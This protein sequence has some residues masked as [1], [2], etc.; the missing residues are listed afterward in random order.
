MAA[1]LCTIIVGVAASRIAQTYYG[2]QPIWVEEANYLQ[3]PSLQFLSQVEHD[4]RFATA[5]EVLRS[6]HILQPLVLTLAA[7]SLLGW[8]YA[9]FLF[10][11][12]AFAIFL[13]LFGWTVYRRAGSLAY[14]VGAMILYLSL[15][16][17]PNERTGIGTAFADIQASLFIAAAALC[18]VN[19]LMEPDRRW[20][21]RFAILV[22]LGA[23]ARTTAASVGVIVC[24][25]M[26]LLY[27]WNEYRA[28]R[29]ARAALGTLATVLV[30][31]A[32]AALLVLWQLGDL[33][34]YY[35]FNWVLGH[36]IAVSATNMRNIV[37]G[38]VGRPAILVCLLLFGLG[39]IWAVRGGAGGR[40]AEAGQGRRPGQGLRI[41]SP[42]LGALWWAV[43]FL[44]FLLVRG[45]TSDVPKEMMYAVPAF[46]LVAVSPVA[47]SHGRN[48]RGWRAVGVAMMVFGLASFGRNVT[49]SMQS[50]AH[51]ERRGAAMRQAQL[52]MAA[53]LAGLPAGI[54][55]QSYAAADW[56]IPVSL[57]TH[58]RFG[59]FREAKNTLFHNT[60]SYW[61]GYYPGA[62]AAE[63]QRQLYAKTVDSV[64]VAIVLKDAAQKP[65]RMEDYSYGMAAYIAE[66][67]QSDGRWRYVGELSGEPYGSKLAIYARAPR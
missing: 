13:G 27:L 50:A 31:V 4:G 29:Q 7:P 48:G 65:D 24:G 43:G 64:D 49:M 33:L 15:R 9:H 46:V 38:F 20:I 67:V 44:G 52:E 54:T 62:S 18:L 2:H 34:W 25:P 42:E 11:L 59:K 41:G 51:V 36:T 28:R 3:W 39:L 57:A 37:V 30:V 12:P 23:L 40:G 56:G 17:L 8:P 53:A 5:L 10:V 19:A 14:A 61:D 55:W 16:G 22:S 21:F 47:V 32:P 6:R 26:L 1:L 66:Q 58:Y 45:Y 60:K 35:S 63:I